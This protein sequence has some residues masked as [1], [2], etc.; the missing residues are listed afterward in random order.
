MLRELSRGGFKVPMQG[1]VQWPTPTG[2]QLL[3]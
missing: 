2:D 1:R 3:L